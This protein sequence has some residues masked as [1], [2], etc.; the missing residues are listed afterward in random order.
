MYNFLILFKLLLITFCTDKDSKIAKLQE[1]L[2]KLENEL[3]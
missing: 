1:T 3:K 2:Q